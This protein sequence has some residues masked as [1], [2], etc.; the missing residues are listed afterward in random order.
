MSIS[1]VIFVNVCAI[2]F[3]YGCFSIHNQVEKW[4][5]KI[6]QQEKTQDKLKNIAFI[7]FFFLWFYLS[8]NVLLSNI[9][10]KVYPTAV[11]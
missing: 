6:F 11:R 2:V 10:H 4:I 9:P 7:I 5:K 8:L 3:G 1:T